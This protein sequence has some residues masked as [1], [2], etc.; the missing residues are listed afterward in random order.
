MFYIDYEYKEEQDKQ[1]SH[2]VE[3]KDI[4]S[5]ISCHE[6]DGIR[7]QTPNIE[8]SIKKKNVIVLI[9][10]GS[11]YKFIHY[12]LAKVL[13]YFIYLTPKWVISQSVVSM[14]C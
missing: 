2:Q 11:N 13:N 12:K 9:D 7:T 1:P 10:F 6:L 14:L 4:T 5:A 8:G 3:I